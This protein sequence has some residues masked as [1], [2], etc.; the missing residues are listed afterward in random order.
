MT[1]AEKTL[2][3]RGLNF[4][5]PPRPPRF[6]DF[7][8]PFEK[9]FGILKK[10]PIAKNS[11]NGFNEELIKTRIKHIALMGYKTYIPPKSIFSDDEFKIIKGLQKDNNI[12]LIKPDKGNGVVIIN[13]MDYN[14]RML[15]ILDDNTKFERINLKKS[16]IYKETTRREDAVRTLI[17]ELKFNDIISE[18]LSKELN[19]IG[20][21]P[22]IMYGLPKVH[23]PNFP[24]RPIISAIGTYSYKLAKFL[25]PLLRPFSTNTFTINDTFSFVKESR[26]LQINTNDVI[27]ASFDVKS[28][29]TNIPLDDTIDIIINKCFP[30]ATQYTLSCHLSRSF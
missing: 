9:L 15:N 26:E 4:S 8:A 23:K 24:L 27:M 18:H 17:N 2:L 1:D 21:R 20:S 11:I 25:V 7:L 5:L 29:F 28:H 30:S 19:P 12:Y 14:S 22:G 3:A 16:N 13:R 10:E 6:C